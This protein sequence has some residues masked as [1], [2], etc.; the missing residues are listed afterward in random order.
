MT[1]QPI[2]NK[3]APVTTNKQSNSNDNTPKNLKA[4]V[5]LTSA[6]G[7][8]TSLALIAKSQGFSLKP[9][10][11][12]KTPI[13]DWAI[14][15]IT[16]EN[17]P[18]EKIM[19]FGWKEIMGI[20]L[21]S[22]AGG[23]TGG[24]LFDKKENMTHKFQEAVNQLIGDITI[25]LSFVALPTMAYKKF[26]D[27]ALKKTKHTGLQN[28]SKYIQSNKVLKILCP[29]LISCSSL[30]AGIIAGNK[31]SNKLNEHF[32]GKKTERG[33]RITDF[34][35]HIDDVCL[36][37]TL[38]ASNSPLGDIVSKFVP[39]ALCVAGIETGTA[40]PEKREKVVYCKDM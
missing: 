14:F 11:I 36:A 23:L 32:T 16:D 29:T 28:I 35:P 25:P 1:I 19:K 9:S 7:V 15:K 40:N 3:I 24:A 27:L 10:S 21:S 33:I 20:G 30:A 37:I 39:V 31:V 26:E 22:V 13:K 17:R 8:A 6:I 2:T 18:D 34:A 5:A 4:K 38:M 12:K